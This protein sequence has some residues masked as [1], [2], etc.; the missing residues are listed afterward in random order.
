MK[1]KQMTD[2]KEHGDQ[3]MI[4]K[5]K[6]AKTRVRKKYKC[7]VIEISTKNLV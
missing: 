2:S 4:Y 6:K 1:G 5:S 3:V 7:N